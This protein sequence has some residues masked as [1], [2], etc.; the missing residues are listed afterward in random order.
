MTTKDIADRLAEIAA[1]ITDA[2]ATMNTAVNAWNRI[3]AQLTILRE[4]LAGRAQSRDARLARVLLAER[5]D[6]DEY[7]RIAAEPRAEQ[8][9]GSS[10]ATASP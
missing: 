10:T 9:N 4:E 2:Q 3:E 7:R 5:F 8:S 6:V 1:D